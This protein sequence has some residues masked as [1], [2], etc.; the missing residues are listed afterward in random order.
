MPVRFLGRPL[1]PL[2]DR[3]TGHTPTKPTSLARRWLYDA[4]LVVLALGTLALAADAVTLARA[5]P[6][7]FQR[8]RVVDGLLAAL[9]VALPLLCGLAALISVLA[10]PEH[11][12]LPAFGAPVHLPIYLAVPRLASPT[13]AA[14]PGLVVPALPALAEPPPIIEPPIIEP[15][16]I[17]PPIIEPPIIEP[18][19][20]GPPRD[21]GQPIR[22]RLPRLR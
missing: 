6:A 12:R 17:E 15:P 16:I 3:L 10:A 20:R 11:A 1:L 7:A 2:L 4:V 13:P 19:A 14:P 22:R 5:T 21:G 9:L 18:L 8:M